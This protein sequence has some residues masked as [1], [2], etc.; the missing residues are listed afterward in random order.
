MKIV[1]VRRDTIDPCSSV[2]C[3]KGADSGERGAD[4]GKRVK[5]RGENG[6]PFPP[7][8]FR[9]LFSAPLPYSSRL[10]PLSFDVSPLSEHLEQANS[11]AE[12]N[13]KVLIYI[14]QQRVCSA[15]SENWEVQRKNSDPRRESNPWTPAHRSDALTTDLQGD[16]WRVQFLCDT[17]ISWCIAYC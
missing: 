1:G 4:W 6:A 8:F 10:A 3:P 5:K 11:S 12:T 14:F 13:F 16:P 2:A 9:L 17:R 7:A 15:C